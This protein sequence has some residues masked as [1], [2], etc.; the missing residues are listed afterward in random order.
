MNLAIRGIDAHLGDGDSFHHDRHPD[1]KADWVLANPPFNDSDWRPARWPTGARSHASSPVQRSRAA[2]S[3]RTSAGRSASRRRAMRTS[4]GCSHLR[5]QHLA[6][7]GIRRR[8]FRAGQRVDVFRAALA[9]GEIRRRIGLEAAPG[10][11]HGARCRGQLFLTRRRSARL[12]PCGYLA[13]N[14][15]VATNG[16]RLSRSARRQ[17]LFIDA[18]KLADLGGPG[19]R[20]A[21]AMRTWAGIAGTYHASAREAAQPRTP[22]VPGFC[23]AAHA[24][25]TSE[26]T[27]A[28]SRPADTSRRGGGG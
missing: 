4:L 26:S 6:P 17:R 20:E 10:G 5:I 25:M 3:R 9:T 2:R 16:R 1:L 14:E 18:R 24:S 13:R 8:G 21:R 12:R 23:K 28:C 7:T 22:S 19:A 27:A 11:L 15:D